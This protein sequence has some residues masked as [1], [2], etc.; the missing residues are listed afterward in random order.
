MYPN[1]QYCFCL[2]PLSVLHCNDILRE[3]LFY[4][5]LINKQFPF[6]C[7]ENNIDKDELVIRISLNKDFKKNDYG[8]AIF[9]KDDGEILAA[10]HP[11]MGRMV[12]W[13]ASIPFIFKPPAMSYV[14]AQFDILVRITTSK[15]KAEQALTETKV[16]TLLSM[17]LNKYILLDDLLCSIAEYFYE[18]CRIL[19]K[20]SKNSQRYYT[21]KHLIRDLL[22]N[23]PNCYVRGGRTLQV[24]IYGGM[25]DRSS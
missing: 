24:F 10:V 16:I 19:A 14:Q 3:I 20:T 1:S 25:R 6:F 8:E 4:I 2:S 13:N 11:K 12:V 18:L 7:T 17:G 23:T 15:E 22:S 5:F 21:T 9:Y